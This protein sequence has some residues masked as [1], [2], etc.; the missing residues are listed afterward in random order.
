M[1]GSSGMGGIGIVNN[2]RSR[3][4]RRHPETGRRLRE[5]LGSDGEVADASTPE[6]LA[7][8]L[9]RFRSERIDLLGVNGGDG[10]AHVVLTAFARAYDGAALPRLL[11]LPG[12]SMNTVADAHGIRGSPER[13]LWD[14]VTRRRAGL[15]LRAVDRDLLRVQADGGDPR[16][17]FIFGTG[18]AVAFLEA[19]YA[20][21]RT[22]PAA[23]GWL[24]VRA[25]ASALIDGPLAASIA[26]R[27]R[28]RVTTDGDEWPDQAYLGVVA[29][30]VPEIG[31]GFRVFARCDEQPGFFHAVGVTG[32]VAQVA[33]SIP[34]IRRGRPWRRRVA[35]DE[36]AR[37]LVVSGD[38]PRFTVDGDLYAARRE[39]R[40]A[41]GPAV[42]VVV[43]GRPRVDPPRSGG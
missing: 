12:G 1:E 5:L 20:A 6:E 14:V 24:V 26:V 15:P 36:V 32:S 40:V 42:E 4:N 29:G 17:G 27:E 8:A 43:P 30:S 39:I 16:Y 25:I 10:T 41:T 7:R 35:L 22:S 3:R 9:E 18:A 11:L 38:A 33:L 21:G 13:V 19:Y 2:P 37:E 31:F 28:L 34:R 23:A